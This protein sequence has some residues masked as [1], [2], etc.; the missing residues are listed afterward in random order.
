MHEIL[1]ITDS[2]VSRI[3][4]IRAGK[5]DKALRLSVSEAGCAG[6]Q[7]D[8]DFADAPGQHD[9]KIEK[10]GETIYVDPMS[11][12]YIVGTEIDWVEN[13][14]ERKFVFNNPNQT[15]ECGCGQSFYVG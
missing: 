4:T 14:F 15:G 9:E 11:L 2:A 3:R 1:K 8:F 12:I 10:D 6:K 7:Y 13:G 5:Q